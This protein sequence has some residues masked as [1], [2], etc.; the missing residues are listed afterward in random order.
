MKFIP[1]LISLVALLS[2]CSNKQNQ[3]SQTLPYFHTPDFTPVWITDRTALDTLH[4]L[5]DFSFVNQNG[6]AITAAT[7][8]GKI[9]VAN[10]FF[11]FCPSLCPKIMSNM[12]QVQEE[13]KTAPDV[14]IASYSVIPERDSVPVLRAYATARGII[15]DRW[16]LIT[17]RQKQLYEIA[18]RS[19]FADENIGIQRGENDFLHTENFILVDKNL[20]IRGIYNGTLPLE[21]TQLV[22]DIKTLQKER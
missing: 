6:Q 14:L 13:F 21:I 5:A 18:R 20:H 4:T 15:D 3:A 2:A 1:I 7:F 9:H 16:H 19:Y 11:T 17:G 12:K 10:Y 22:E 8:K